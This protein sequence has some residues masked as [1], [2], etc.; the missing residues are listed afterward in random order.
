IK[1]TMRF[2]AGPGPLELQ[3]PNWSPGDYELKLHGKKVADLH[4]RDA[5]GAPV[6]FD[7]AAD[8]SWKGAVAESGEVTVDYTVP[9]QFE[10]GALHF[11]GAGPYPYVGRR[12]KEPGHLTLVSPADWKVAV[13]LDPTGESEIEYDAPGYDVLADNPVTAGDFIE[14]HYT[15]H[16][17]P[18]TIALRGALR[19]AL[20]PEKIVDLL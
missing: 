1:V 7:H 17:K 20:E 16:G 15:S 11:G 2:E 4:G 5:A 19:S 13:G 18:L 6:A 10:A 14:L 12:H 8:N 9:A 3:M